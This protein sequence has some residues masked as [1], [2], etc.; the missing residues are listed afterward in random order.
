MTEIHNGEMEPGDLRTLAER[1]LQAIATAQA[2]GSSNGAARAR[3]FTAHDRAEQLRRDTTGVW[4]E[5]QRRIESVARE[6]RVSGQPPERM[7]VSLKQLVDASGIDFALRREIEADVMRW[8]I[9]AFY[10]A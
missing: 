4:N 2:L 1:A 8:G 10:A 7:L 6:E 3:L 5:L 9:D